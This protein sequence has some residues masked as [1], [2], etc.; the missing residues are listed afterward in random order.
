MTLRIVVVGVVMMLL[1]YRMSGIDARRVVPAR[2]LR[3]RRSRR[4]CSTTSRARYLPTHSVC[5]VQCTETAR[6]VHCAV[7]ISRMYYALGVHYAVLR[8][9]VLPGQ[10]GGARGALAQEDRMPLPL[11]S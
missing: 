11:C 5:A 1:L 7:L 8:S 4:M 2:R 9:R 10:S 3:G 6:G